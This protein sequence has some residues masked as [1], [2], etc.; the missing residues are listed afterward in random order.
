[1]AAATLLDRHRLTGAVIAILINEQYIYPTVAS[2]QENQH[3]RRGQIRGIGDR[4]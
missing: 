3:F 2:Y 4:C 1:V